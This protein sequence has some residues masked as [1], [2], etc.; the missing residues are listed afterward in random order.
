MPKLQNSAKPN[1]GDSLPVFALEC[2]FA[3]DTG[4][5]GLWLGAFGKT[6]L[7]MC[8]SVPGPLSLFCDTELGFCRLCNFDLPNK[9]RFSLQRHKS[10]KKLH[11]LWQYVL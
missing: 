7:F 6:G 1:S 4:G 9:Q 11:F 5:L 2:V 3:F 8:Q 10:C